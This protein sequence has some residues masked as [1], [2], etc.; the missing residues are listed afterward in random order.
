MVNTF[1]HTENVLLI[2]DTESIIGERDGDGH[3]TSIISTLLNLSDSILND[4]FKIQIL[5]T[6]N[7]KLDNIDEAFLRSERLIAR[8]EF[9]TLSNE[10]ALALARYLDLEGP[11]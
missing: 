5:L 2:E 9:G 4:I 3:R 10:E 8:R 11:F 1:S 6:F 7:T